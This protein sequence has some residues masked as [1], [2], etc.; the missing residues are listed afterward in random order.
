MSINGQ[1]LYCSRLN[2]PVIMR[3][4]G[5]AVETPGNRVLGMTESTGNGNKFHAITDRR[6]LRAADSLAFQVRQT[7]NWIR[8]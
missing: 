4:E 2:F 5:S 8:G 6:P 1:H 7:L 3:T